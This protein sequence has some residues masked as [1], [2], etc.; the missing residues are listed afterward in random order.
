MTAPRARRRPAAQGVTLLT[1]PEAAERLSS[2]L[3]HVYRLITVGE[4]AAV[5]IAQPGAKKS[6]TRV[7]SDE[8]DRYIEAKTR[9]VP[10][11]RTPSPA[12]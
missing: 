6:K 11:D 1:V 5:D 4:L 2:G 8:L 9:S 3:S 7:R 10:A 12:A